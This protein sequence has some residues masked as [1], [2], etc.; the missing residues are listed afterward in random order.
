MGDDYESA[1]AAG[2]QAVQILREARHMDPEA[3]VLETIAEIH[4]Q[5]DE[6]DLAVEVLEEVLK[7]YLALSF[8]RKEVDTRHS[9][10]ELHLCKHRYKKVICDAR[11]A[12]TKYKIG[13]AKDEYYEA[14]MLFDMAT[15]RFRQIQD[16]Y[17]TIRSMLERQVMTLKEGK[18]LMEAMLFAK[19]ALALFRYLKDWEHEA[20]T[21]QLLVKIHRAKLEPMD[22]IN[23]AKEATDVYRD[24]EIKYGIA[25]TRLVVAI[26][27]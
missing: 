27:H 17:P 8:Q 12:L 25:N 19:D 21:L 14:S 2:K 26:C 5:N 13:S 24:L 23:V 9:I 20:D 11:E 3:K 4:V 7:I 15:A 16:K 1:L 6:S 22:A 10:A 18:T